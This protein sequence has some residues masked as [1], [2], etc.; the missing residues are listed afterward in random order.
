MKHITLFFV[1]FFL[2]C[3]VFGS[4]PNEREFPQPVKP[5]VVSE[6]FL[7]K[8]SITNERSS[9]DRWFRKVY[10]LQYKTSVFEDGTHKTE[11]VSM[12]EKN[13]IPVYVGYGII[14]L[15]VCVMFILLFVFEI[16]S[17]KDKMKSHIE[18]NTMFVSQIDVELF[19]QLEKRRLS[20]HFFYLSGLLMI[21][22]GFVFSIP[23]CTLVF[24]CLFLSVPFFAVIETMEG[25]MKRKFREFA[26]QVQADH[27]KLIYKKRNRLDFL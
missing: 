14:F 15:F 2:S 11:L 17:A 1:F 27:E 8:D 19:W 4:F 10:A 22:F 20:P 25:Y 3:F 7:I 6:R 12:Q 9:F 13:N 18:K 23:F 21:G 26:I 16:S 5:R 24:F